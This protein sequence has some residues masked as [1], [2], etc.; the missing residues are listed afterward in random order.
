LIYSSHHLT[1]RERE[2]Q[3]HKSDVL[4]TLAQ[5]IQVSCHVYN[6]VTQKTHNDFKCRERRF[7]RRVYY[8][9]PSLKQSLGGGRL[10]ND[11]EVERAVTGLLVT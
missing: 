5:Q 10:K 8:L 1:E 6:Y 9:F 4:K 11:R 7:L 2:K 3:G